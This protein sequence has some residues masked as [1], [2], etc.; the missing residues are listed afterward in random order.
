MSSL[1]GKCRLQYLEKETAIKQDKVILTSG[2]NGMFPKGYVIGY[3]REVQ[4]DDT[5]LTAA[6]VLEPAS[7]IADLSMVIVVKDY[8]GKGRDQ[9]D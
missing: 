4:V 3:V 9:H 1:N 8:N 7:D 6:A 2:E 5:G